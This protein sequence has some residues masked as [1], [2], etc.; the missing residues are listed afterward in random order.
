MLFRT[1]APYVAQGSVIHWRGGTGVEWWYRFDG[2]RL[3]TE[4]D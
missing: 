2:E 3:I 4:P 1:V